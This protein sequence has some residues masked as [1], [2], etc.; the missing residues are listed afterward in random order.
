VVR[1]RVDIGQPEANIA[2]NIHGGFILAY[3][4]QAP[5]CAAFL[6]DRLPAGGAVTL[7]ASA[8]FIAPGRTDMPLDAL[9]EIIGETGRMLFVRG[10]MEQEGRNVASFE[11]TLRKTPTRAD[12]IAAEG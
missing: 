2:D 4:D 10:M 8:A 6:L 7:A 5:F 11:A 1:V 12:R 3:I 9:V